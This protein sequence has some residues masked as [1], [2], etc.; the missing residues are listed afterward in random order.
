VDLVEPG[1]PAVSMCAKD[2]GSYKAAYYFVRDFIR[3]HL[4]LPAGG[5]E[6]TL[7]DRAG[8]CLG[9]VA[10]LASLCRAMGMPSLAVRVVTGEIAVGDALV[11]HAW[12]EIEH[13]GVCLQRDPTDL[14]AWFDFRQFPGTA[15]TEPFVRKEVFRCNDD[16]FA[17]VSQL[18]R[19]R[20]GPPRPAGCAPG[21]ELL[22]VSGL[23]HYPSE[24][25]V[26][27]PPASKIM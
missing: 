4:N 8:S 18:T 5:P 6:Q 25:P 2:L 3:F 15:Y 21:P 13:D 20:H 23:R 16:G 27:T 11:E 14:L 7:R 22:A 17:V 9:K 1:S 24:E 12:V 26:L 19:F 10:L